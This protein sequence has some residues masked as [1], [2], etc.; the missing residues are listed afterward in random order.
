MPHRFSCT[1]CGSLGSCSS[2]D[3][4]CRDRAGLGRSVCS[5]RA[6]AA[7][8]EAPAWQSA[9]CGRSAPAS[10][11]ALAWQ[12]G[13]EGPAA[14]S[15]ERRRSRAGRSTEPRLVPH[16]FSCTSCGS[17]SSRDERWRCSCG[18]LRILAGRSD[19]KPGLERTEGRGTG[20]I[21]SGGSL[22]SHE[23]PVDVFSA[24][25]A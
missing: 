11:A 25:S 22:L 17:C 9:P 10:A 8:D 19:G 15:Q 13:E 1:S 2:R 21:A 12:Q 3:E 24:V 7:D 18:A 16:R 4:R 23:R 20:E 5:S 6:H 14:A